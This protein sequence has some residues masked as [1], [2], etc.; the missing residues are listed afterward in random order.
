MPSL[1]F[2]LNRP[3]ASKALAVW[4]YF[5]GIQPDVYWISMLIGIRNHYFGF[6]PLA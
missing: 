2:G 6:N 1:M 3:V 4:L 5:T